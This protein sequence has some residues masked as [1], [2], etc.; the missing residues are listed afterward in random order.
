MFSQDLLGWSSG[1]EDLT[2]AEK[3]GQ[4]FMPTNTLIHETED[5]SVT[6]SD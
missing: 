3:W 1:M 5:K 2:F 6:A 4:M